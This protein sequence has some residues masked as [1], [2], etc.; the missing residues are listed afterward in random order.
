MRILPLV[1]MVALLGCGAKKPPETPA[2][3]TP[4]NPTPTDTTTPPPTDTTTPPP[5]DTTPTTSTTPAS[6]AP[7]SDGPLDRAADLLDKNDPSSAAQAESMLLEQVK[8]HPDDALAY[9][10][11]GVAKYQEGDKTAARTYWQTATQK[12]SSVG[13]AWLYLGAL[14]E[15]AGDVSGAVQT[16]R[17][18]VQ[19]DPDNT[20]VRAALVGAL[21]T[22]GQNDQAVAEAK[23]ALR[24]NS[25]SLSIYNNL[26]LVY[27]DEGNLDLA[28]FVYMKAMQDNDLA[29]NDAYI[30][31]NLGRI[32][33]LRGEKGPALFNLQAAVQLDPTLVPALIY[34]SQIY[35]ADHNYADMVPLLETARKEDPN[36]HGVLMNLGIA[37]RGVGRLDEAKQA[38]ESALQIDPRDPD[39]YFNL[40]VLQS[41][42]MKL[43][44]EA[45]KS[46][47]QYVS[48]GGKNVQQAKDYIDAVE[49]EKK[50]VEKQKAK[51]AEKQRKLQEQQQKQ[52]TPPTPPS[53]GSGG[54]P[55]PPPTPTP[56][57][58][59]PPT[60]PAPTPDQPAPTP[61]PGTP[62]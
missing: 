29:K 23:A 34:L 27:M 25:N 45:I 12:D 31:C 48:Q 62:Q 30:R 15:E 10:D 47:Q 20:D 5:T 4:A 16:Y 44:D 19:D 61:T 59:Q 28:K 6:T 2:N 49:K 35:L 50:R 58:D 37:Y 38:Y 7:A 24:I 33:F 14:Q 39:P 13:N 56:P 40:G 21:H 57:P 53:D 32:Y 43:Y 1:A 52:Q 17:F 3:P 55:A 42:Y 26:G 22:L 18:G 41:D 51:E 36:N 60:T 9:V 46:F 8:S 54:T 11:L